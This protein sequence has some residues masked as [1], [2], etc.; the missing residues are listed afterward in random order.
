MLTALLQGMAA[1]VLAQHKLAFGHSHRLGI[2]DLVGGFLLQIAVLMNAGFVREG[3][4][5]DDGLVGLGSEG[6]DGAQELAG[7]VEVLGV[8]AGLEGEAVV[9]GLH[10]HDDLFERAVAGALADTINSAFDLPGAG[11]HGG[12]GIGYG[13]AQV[14]MAMHADY[15]AIAESFH[16]RA[17]QG[18]ILFGH[19]V[20][21]RIRN[22][23]GAGAGG[24][25]GF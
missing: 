24:D 15:G 19:R 17:D 10:G 1:A 16:D 6:D 3:V 5:A 8:D 12:D 7:R 11:L 14:V 9:A 21:Y 18:A 4:A 2:D 25:Y 23:D 13:E 20:T 22:I